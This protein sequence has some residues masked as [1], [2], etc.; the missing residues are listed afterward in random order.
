MSTQSSLLTLLTTA[1]SDHAFDQNERHALFEALADARI[2]DARF[3]RNK[4]FDLA[5]EAV[6][7]GADTSAVLRWLERVVKVVDQSTAQAQVTARA[8]FSPGDACRQAIIQ[9]L[10]R[11]RSRAYICVFT[12]SD[13]RIT[14]AII[15]A[16]QRGIDVRVISDNDKQYDA[17]SDI[18]E[19]ID[20]GVA[21]RV[22]RTRHH[23]HHKFALLDNTLINGSFNWTRS[24]SDYNRENI[25][26]TENSPVMGD[27]ESIFDQLWS[28]YE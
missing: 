18:A 16:N 15:D 17:G 10:G 23:M 4:A 6:T 8:F 2:D 20:T 3:I 28:K 25:T 14:R 11:V 9:A 12:L 7:T 21:V 13:D 27:F 19:L 5:Q 24:A 22:D 26:A 1:V